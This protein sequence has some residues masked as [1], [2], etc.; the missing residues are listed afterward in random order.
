VLDKVI[1]SV[2]PLVRLPV[3]LV[4]GIESVIE[5]ATHV[6][7]RAARVVDRAEPVAAR[8][9][10]LLDR[11]EQVPDRIDVLLVRS[12]EA[13]AAVESL[14]ASLQPF[15]TALAAVDPAAVPALVTEAA[16]LVPALRSLE[17]LVPVVS[18]LGSQVDN[19]DRT[20]AEVGTLLGGLPGAA[21][22]LK[23][24]ETARPGR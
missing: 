2:V 24:G 21:R 4:E 13:A 9:E 12:A 5:Q 3:T 22:L 14:V 23:R 10:A 20:V 18:Q 7:T 8:I 19:L 11:A 17:Q 16:E 1:G 6:A 15:V